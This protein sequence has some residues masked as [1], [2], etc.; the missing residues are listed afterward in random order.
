MK[1]IRTT[2]KPTELQKAF[3]RAIESVEAE[4]EYRKLMVVEELLQ[5]VKRKGLSKGELASRMGVG[6]SR[7]TALLSG[8]SN[9]TIDTLVRAGRAVDADLVQT[10]VPRGQKGV[11]V[12]KSKPTSKDSGGIIYNLIPQSKQHQ[13]NM[14]LTTTRVA[15]EDSDRAA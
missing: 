11:W 5:F 10:F 1:I 12:S 6:N 9:L 15:K 7:V 14:G 4:I 3:A 2:S 13:I 8:D